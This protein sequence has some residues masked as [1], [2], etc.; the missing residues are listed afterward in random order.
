[1]T[2]QLL[3]LIPQLDEYIFRLDCSHVF[4]IRCLVNL[5]HQRKDKLSTMQAAKSSHHMDEI[6]I[7]CLYNQMVLYFPEETKA[8][9]IANNKESTLEK[10]P[11]LKNQRKCVIL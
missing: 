6:L 10:F 4:C 8:K 2:Q 5:Q 9:Q 1:M 11:H 3:S 7:L